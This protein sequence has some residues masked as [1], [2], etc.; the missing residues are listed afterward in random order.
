VLNK[1]TY[2]FLELPHASSILLLVPSVLEVEVFD[3]G[4]KDWHGE[5]S[6]KS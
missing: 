3:I 5:V 1:I 6:T 2:Y 4:V